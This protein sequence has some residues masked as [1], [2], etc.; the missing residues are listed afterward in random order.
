[1]GG[2]IGAKIF[3]GAGGFSGAMA[4]GRRGNQT[5]AQVE[6]KAGIAVIRYLISG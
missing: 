6:R 1:M 2:E 5:T 4:A 3:A